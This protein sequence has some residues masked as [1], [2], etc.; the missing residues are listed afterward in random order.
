M[1]IVYRHRRLDNN[2]VFYVGIGTNKKRAYEKG[3]RNN[4]WQKVIEK[5]EYV[6]EVIAEEIE[7]EYAQELEIF[8]ISIY[9]RKDLNTG[10]LANLT[11]GGEG[12]N[13]MSAESRKRISEAITIRNKTTK[14]SPTQIENRTAK[15]RG[16]KRTEEQ[17][18]KLKQTQYEKG[19][20]NPTTVYNYYT[21]EKLGEFQSLCEACRF[22]GFIPEKDSA[23]A[24]RV[25][26][27]ERNH[28]KGYVFE[29]INKVIQK[30]IKFPK[31]R[32]SA[33]GRLVLNIE[34]GIFY[35]SAQEAYNTIKL[36]ITKGSFTRKLKGDRVNDTSF[37]YV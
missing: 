11:S 8:L 12:S 29:Y 3:G 5:T 14:Q 35:I 9:G 18:N 27:K 19:L 22:L 31:T 37:I 34:T 21:E 24:S 16:Q 20:T 13:N 25:A 30:P 2:E 4:L 26:R 23:K 17:T 32:D 6:V 28:Y 36:D 1:A 33:E 10:I 7:M 15:L